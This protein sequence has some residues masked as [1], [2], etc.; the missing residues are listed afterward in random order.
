MTE[1]NILERIEC[2]LPGMSK[3]HKKIGM[4]VLNHF[5]KAVFMTAA[6]LGRELEISESTVVRFSMALGYEGYPAMQKALETC[7][8]DRLTGKE[9]IGQEYYGRSQSEILTSVMRADIEKLQH[10]IE[11]LDAEAFDLAAESILGAER[12]YLMGLRSNAPLANFLHFYLNM[13]RRDVILLSTNNLNETYEQMM[14]ITEKDCFI[15]ISF[16]RY[17]IRTLKAM[18][19]ANDRNAKVVAIT[20]NVNSPLNLYSS[21]NLCARSDMI[22]IVDS[23]VAPLSVINALLVSLVLKNPVEVR[24]NMEMLEQVWKDYQVY[25]NDEIDPISDEPFYHTDGGEE[26]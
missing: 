17:S 21:C 22:S 15:G 11:H 13:I 2:S 5:D 14:Y 10:T 18:E 26:G 16:P 3:S 7:V 23:L 1:K 24:K 4:F 25:V 9:G 20:D 12:V 8:Q 19:F 6:T